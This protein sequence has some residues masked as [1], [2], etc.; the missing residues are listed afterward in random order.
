MQV[1]SH[2]QKQFYSD[3]ENIFDGKMNIKFKFPLAV[4]TDGM[5]LVWLQPMYHT[6]SWYTVANGVI[7]HTHTKGNDLNINV[8]VDLP[9]TDEPVTYKIKHG[10]VLA[11]LWSPQKLKLSHSKKNFVSGFHIKRFVGIGSSIHD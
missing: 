3:K 9:E 6:R 11:Y 1:S 7:S 10:E 8:L 2:P 4:R 5:P